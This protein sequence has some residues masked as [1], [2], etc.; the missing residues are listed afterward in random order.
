MGFRTAYAAPSY[1]T[2]TTTALT[3]DQATQVV[4]RYVTALNNPDLKVTEVEEYTNNSYVQVQ[5]VSTGSGA[6]ELLVDKYTGNVYPERGPNVRWN[7]KYTITTGMM[8]LFSGFRGMMGLQR[9]ASTPMTVTEDQAKADAL[10]FLTANYAG[11]TVGDAT[12]F[13]G[14]YT[15]EV[16][17]NGSTY[18]MIGVNGY[19]GQVWYHTWH[20]T[21]I[22]QTELP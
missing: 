19:T 13:Y 12:A 17:Q 16:L 6:F 5:E 11:T 14:Y 18:G 10:Q 7:T 21:F 8:G 9:T 1:T 2:N 4:Q 22:Q 15:I 20:G 3:I